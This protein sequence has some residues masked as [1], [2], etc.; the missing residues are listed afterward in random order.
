MLKSVINSLRSG[1]VG[2]L[3]DFVSPSFFE[4]VPIFESAACLKKLAGGLITQARPPAFDAVQ[5][6]LAA[7]GLPITILDGKVAISTAKNSNESV[8]QATS[9]VGDDLLKIY[10]LQ[11]FGCP[12]AVLDMR[13]ASF[14]FD[15][16]KGAWNPMRVVHR[17]RDDFIVPIRLIYRGFYKNDAGAFKRGLKELG[18]QSAEELFI[19]HFGA[20]DQ[21]AVTFSGQHFRKSFHDI[22][23]HCKDNRIKLHVDFLPFGILLG[24]LYEN[25]SHGGGDHNVRKVFES[26]ITK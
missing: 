6:F 18:L 26:V 1:A 16:G 23:V 15:Q 20:G 12:E 17:W 13:F 21:T 19:R 11:L 9:G 7:S 14:N 3:L 8:D 24:T 5:A 2:D 22:F 10:F 25:L 4:V